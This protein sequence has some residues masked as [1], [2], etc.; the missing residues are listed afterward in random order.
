[1]MNLSSLFK[2]QISVC[3]TFC[4]VIAIYLGAS[5]DVVC[6]I[7]FVTGV[8]SIIFIQKAISEIDRTTKIVHSLK[9]GDFE[10]RILNLKEGGN[11][12]DMQLGI[13]D[14]IDRID[15]FVR[16]ATA[17]MFC[18]NEGNYYRRI[19][20]AGM[21]GSLLNGCKIINAAADSFEAAQ[22]DFANR[23]MSLTDDF[24][25]N[26]AVFMRD[27]AVSMEELSV[28]SSAMSQISEEGE[29]RSVVLT[30]SVEVATTNVNT[31]ASAAEELSASIREIVTQITMSSQISLDA[32]NKALEANAA[33]GALK[34]SSDKIGEVVVLIK[35]IAE[36]TNLLALNATIEA[37]RAGDA[38]KGF[39]VVASEVKAL[40]S[41]TAGAT[42]E[43]EAQVNATKTSVGEAVD[44]ISDV[45]KIIEQMN[46]ISTSISAAME[47]QSA[48]MDDIV[49][50]TQGAADNTNELS[51]VVAGATESSL[52]IK[53]SS[54]DLGDATDDIS[55][56]TTVL[57]GE[58][59]IFLSNI[60]TA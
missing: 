19:L 35:D 36:Q 39:A 54:S 51:E 2:A 21:H 1:M 10:A 29:S 12:G 4:S 6:V 26:V 49:R 48:V 30:N 33:I 41:Q 43:I 13:N 57:Q 24:D 45:S 34:I 47:E 20:E 17:V 9:N 5:V 50:S 38:G 37:A 23:L 40:A 25:T 58:I 55:K 56:R 52:Q 8:T 28:T 32:V 18:I 3:M 59:E 11:L 14:M 27:L 42:D 16:E 53:S 22:K 31:V 44:V 15:A 7:A 60:K 46:E